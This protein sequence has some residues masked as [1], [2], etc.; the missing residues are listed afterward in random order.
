MHILQSDY[1]TKLTSICKHVALDTDTHTH[2]P[3]RSVQA[4]IKLS[5]SWVLEYDIVNNI[6]LA[7]K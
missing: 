6:T 5:Y 3:Q 4:L 1:H 2:T 7:M